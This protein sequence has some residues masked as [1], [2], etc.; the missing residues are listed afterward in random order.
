MSQAAISANGASQQLSDENKKLNEINYSLSG[1]VVEL[2]REVERLNLEVKKLARELRIANSFLDKVTKASA[3]KDTLNDALSDVNI[4]QRAYTDL[5]LQ[6]CPNIIMLL[7]DDGRFVL[8]THAFMIA[9]GTPNF[10]YIKNRKY[11][12]VFPKYFAAD[13]IGIFTDAFGHVVSSGEMFQ[14]SALIDFSLTGERRFY[15]LEL[16]RAGFGAGHKGD[17]MSGV[18]IV[19]VDLTDFMREKQRAEAANNAKSEFLATM[20]HEIRTPMNAIIGM[21]EMLDRSELTPGQKKYVYDIRRSSSALLAIINDILDFSRIEA[22]KLELVSVN[23]NLKILIANLHSMFSMLCREKHLEIKCTYSGDL[24]EIIFGN[25]T[26]IR[27]ILTNLL[28]NAVKYTQHGTISFS[29]HIDGSDLLFEVTDTGIGIRDEDKNKLFKPFEQLDARKNRNIVGTGLGLAI[30]YNL[31]RLMGG[32]LFFDS[33]YGEG[34]TFHVRIPYTKADDSVIDEYLDVDEFNAPEAKILVVDDIDINL[35][36]AEALLGAFSITPDLVQS[37][38][39]AVER[40]SKCE[41]NIIFMDHMMPEMDGLETTRR[42]RELGG[43]NSE[44]PV[45]ALTAN[46][47]SGVDQHFLNNSL[48]DFLT[49]P[50]D[51]R[52]LNFCL[53]KWLPLEVIKEK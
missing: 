17:A 1:N 11:S 16:R 46:A 2:N 39:E 21:S 22:G 26:R 42:I 36:V 18:L 4:K 50:L 9:T 51:I 40:A 47:I 44:V 6:S 34:S 5:L 25:E 49:K 30:T 53:R 33:I 31:C 38:K 24:P 23:F 45:I 20:S 27:Q 35:A 41:Y 48:N 37:G 14:F 15:S 32:E 19:M 28:S 8:S 7:D 10:E 3:A 12:E 13:D 43:W 52:A 29:T